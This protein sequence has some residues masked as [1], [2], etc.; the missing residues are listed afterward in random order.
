MRITD[1]WL[2]TAKARKTRYDVTT[3]LKGLMI[4]VHPSGALSFRYRYMRGKN[5][6]GHAIQH[7]IILGL[8][9]RRGSGLTLDDAHEFHRKAQRWLA[10]GLDP[11][12]EKR[13]EDEAQ[14]KALHERC[15]AETVS[16]L[17]DE[18]VHRK[19]RGERWDAER[20]AWVRDAKVKTK[21]RKRPEAAAALLKSNLVDAKLDDKKIGDM[22]ARDLTRRHLVRLLDGIVDR[23]APITSNRVHALLRQ[24]FDWAAAK[25]R[26]PASP[27]AG[28]ERPGGEESPR[29]RVLT[30]A[31]IQTFW[32]KV[33]AEDAEM[34]APTRLALKLLLV[35]GQ[36]RGEITLAKWAH[37]DLEAKLW[38]IPVELLKTSHSRRSS[39][40]PHVVPL[41][42]LA[43]EILEQ[44]KALTGDGIYVLPAYGDKTQERSFSERALSRAVRDNEKHF[45]LPH[46]TPHDLRRTAAS[47]M[48]KLKIPRLHVE[49]VLNHATGDIAEIYDRHDYLP[50]KKTALDTWSTE[51]RDIIAGKERKVIQLQRSA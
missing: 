31:E 38:T 35:T 26:I 20:T 51:L 24:L 29:E 12:E 37:F 7:V 25:D 5:A 23:G 32:A 30:A 2:R 39:P 33:E 16:E 9:G 43:L 17:V 48:T 10:L 8:Y 40:E 45:G 49:K 11:A 21:P 34:S 1:T 13:K 44:I 28:I 14:A 41:S 18:F 47:F 19:L 15:E 46:F 50:E 3:E 36:R 6:K 4:R 27:M 42:P 22:K